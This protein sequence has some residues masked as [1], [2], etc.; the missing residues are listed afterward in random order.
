MEAMPREAPATRAAA[1]SYRIVAAARDDDPI[2]GMAREVAH[3]LRD[4]PPWLA[5]KWF[6]DDR[7]SQLFERITLLPEYYLT[8]AEAEILEDHAEALLARV[9]PREILE[10][11][12]GSGRKTRRLVDAGLAAGSLEAVTLFDVHR[13]SLEGWLQGAAAHHPRLELTGIVGDFERDLGSVPACERRMVLFL[14]GTIGNLHPDREVPRLL[15]GVAGLL[16]PG[17]SFLLGV[18]LEKDPD[19]LEAAYDDR[20]GVTAD[21]NRN[22]LRVVNRRLG[23][24]FAPEAWAH[25]AFYDRDRRWI[26]MR[27]RAEEDCRVRVDRAG[28]DLAFREGDEIRTEISCKYTRASLEARLPGTGLAVSEWLTDARGRFALVLLEPSP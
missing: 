5:S 18:D 28:L 15:K 8:R 23:G 24:D 14:G 3:S 4:R 25:V 10:I 26:E 27:L 11:G 2:E 19:V 13:P 22:A 9:R 20:S 6:Y 7:G 17:G 21:F 16:G 1:P 12:S